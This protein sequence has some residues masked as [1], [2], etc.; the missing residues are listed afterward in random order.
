MRISGTDLYIPQNDTTE[1]TISVDPSLENYNFYM[2]V[3]N[4]TIDGVKQLVNN[5]F[6][7][8]VV[9]SIDAENFTEESGRFYYDIFM[10][11]SFNYFIKSI[12]VKSSF[13]IEE[14]LDSN[15]PIKDNTGKNPED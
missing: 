2:F 6:T 7:G 5:A 13:V 15:T 9:F 12:V 3:N 1:L 8:E 14:G 10:V 11:E 4:K